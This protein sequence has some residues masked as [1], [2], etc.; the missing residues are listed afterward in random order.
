MKIRYLFEIWPGSRVVMQRTANPFTSV[1]FR[2]GPPNKEINLL[3]KI[4]VS[5]VALLYTL[6]SIVL[7]SPVAQR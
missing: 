7:W 2:P 6:R 1:R 3:K 4:C 5:R